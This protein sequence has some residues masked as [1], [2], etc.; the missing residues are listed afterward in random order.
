LNYKSD[1][2]PSL[3]LRDNLLLKNSHTIEKSNE[4]VVN[5]VLAAKNNPEI[6]K[7]LSQWQKGK[8]H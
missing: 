3:S 2:L 4:R 7:P 5:A 1:F 6:T 8:S